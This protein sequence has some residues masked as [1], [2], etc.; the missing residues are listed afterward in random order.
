MVLDI[1]RRLQAEIAVSF[2][3]TLFYLL[4]L[5]NLEDLVIE[6]FG[7]GLS[8]YL[9]PQVIISCMSVASIALLVCSCRNYIKYKKTPSAEIAESILGD[10]EE[11]C[12]S[13]GIFLYV[14]IL[15]A[16][17]LGLY[18]FGF[19]YTTPVV[20]FVVA[21]L[22]GMRR[23]LLGIAAS[24]IVTLI[25]EYASLYFLKIMLPNGVFFQ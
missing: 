3:L 5:I 7:A 24:V 21:Y 8:P 4:A 10:S 17:W 16:Y 2:G 6:G 25:L 15:F 14:L 1:V 18:Y 23:I 20:I 13:F 11:V 9:F 22:L 12:F 19:L